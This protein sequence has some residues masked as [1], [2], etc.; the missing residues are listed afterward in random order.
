METKYVVP[1]FKE[2]PSYLFVT[3]EGGR[4]S[5]YLALS[6]HCLLGVAFQAVPTEKMPLV[7]LD[8]VLEGTLTKAAAALD[9]LTHLP[10]LLLQ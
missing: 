8:H 9:Q 2:E 7:A 6:I 10:S 1:I 3:E 4:W 5:C